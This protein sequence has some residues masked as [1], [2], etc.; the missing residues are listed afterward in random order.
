[1]RYEMTF[2]EKLIITFL[3]MGTTYEAAIDAKDVEIDEND[4]TWKAD[5]Q[6][7]EDCD[8]AATAHGSTRYGK[9]STK[10][11]WIDASDN[12]AGDFYKEFNEG[13]DIVECDGMR[14]TAEN[15]Q[16]LNYIPT[17]K[18]AQW[19]FQLND[20][21]I[22]ELMTKDGQLLFK[23]STPIN[24]TTGEVG[25]EP[26]YRAFGR[27]EDT[28][29]EGFTTLNILTKEKKGHTV[30]CY[31]NYDIN[32]GFI[33]TM[34]IRRAVK[35]ARKFQANGFNVR[36]EAV[37]FN[38]EGYMSGGKTGYRDEKNGYH[39]FTPC[40]GTRSASV[41][42]RWSH[43]AATGRRHTWGDS[44][45]WCFLYV[46]GFVM[47]T[48]PHKASPPVFGRTDRNSI[49]FGGNIILSIQKTFWDHHRLQQFHEELLLHRLAIC[50]RYLSLDSLRLFPIPLLRPSPFL[51][52]F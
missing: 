28:L 46:T 3:L 29:P 38:F 27:D 14:W 44:T 49:I 19:G 48:I 1:M 22:I 15:V 17:R 51:L 9:P 5:L 41:P 11:F 25:P 39:L 12:G 8:I 33:R 35:I 37:M 18:D 20:G 31:D 2:N 43:A 13:I 16:H 42:R 52:C 4:G 10:D 7:G 6:M 45:K 50:Q 23:Y 40:K 24:L 30:Y 26:P 36:A 34:T 32:L 47:V 21:R